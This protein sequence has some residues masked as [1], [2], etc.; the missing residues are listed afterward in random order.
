[1]EAAEHIPP[2]EIPGNWF[3]WWMRWSIL[4]DMRIEAHKE[5]AKKSRR[6]RR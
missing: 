2:W 3:V 6:S 4:R 5:A 1:L